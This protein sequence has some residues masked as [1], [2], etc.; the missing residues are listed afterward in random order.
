MEDVIH[1]INHI[2]IGVKDIDQAYPFYHRYLNFSFKLND[3]E[4]A[5]CEL[6]PMFDR[7]P[8]MRMRNVMNPQGGPGLIVSAPGSAHRV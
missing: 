7:Q 6:E 4:N 3:D 1:T 5:L 8:R 2:G